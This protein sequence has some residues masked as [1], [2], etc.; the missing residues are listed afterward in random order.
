MTREEIEQGLIKRVAG[1]AGA[2]VYDLSQ[3]VRGR[4]D[5][6]TGK[7]KSEGG[8]RQT[9]GFPDLWMV[10]RERGLAWWWETKAPGGT[11]RPEQATFRAECLGSGTLHGYGTLTDFLE[12]LEYLG[13]GRR[14]GPDRFIF[15]RRELRGAA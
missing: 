5:E 12:W 1:T 11:L 10:D 4:R 6:G 8:T 14:V 13:Y 9:R 7:W 2:T 3:G 15:K